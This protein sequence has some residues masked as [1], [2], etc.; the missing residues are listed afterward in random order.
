[1]SFFIANIVLLPMGFLAIKASKQMLRV[2]TEVLMPLVLLFC[3]VGSFAI[4]NSLMGVIVILGAGLL[5]FIMQ[6]NGFPVAPLILGMIM[7]ELLEENFM[8]AMIASDGNLLAFFSRPIAATLG[9]VTILVWLTPLIKLVIRKI[10]PQSKLNVISD[11]TTGSC[12]T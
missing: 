5:S 8:Q 10:W 3:I 12:R 9:T 1:V 6:E 4:N 7:G 11:N 2:P